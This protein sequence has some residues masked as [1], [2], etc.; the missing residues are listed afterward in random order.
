M[1][2]LPH[3]LGISRIMI[4]RLQSV[5]QLPIVVLGYLVL[6]DNDRLSHEVWLTWDTT[7]R[8]EVWVFLVCP[9]ISKDAYLGVSTYLFLV[10]GLYLLV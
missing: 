1:W 8:S 9:Q 7:Y 4:D 3:C 10:P 2:D 5:G 6:Q